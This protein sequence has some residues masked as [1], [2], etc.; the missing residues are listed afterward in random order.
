M[1]VLGFLTRRYTPAQFL[2]LLFPSLVVLFVVHFVALELGAEEH[3]AVA[4]SFTVSV[5]ATLIS[6]V[7]INRRISA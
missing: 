4:A 2:R 7:V 6:T 1:R 3:V 5:A